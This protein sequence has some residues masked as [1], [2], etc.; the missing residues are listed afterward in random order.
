MFKSKKNLFLIVILGITILTRF[1]NLNWGSPYFFHPDE[2]NMANAVTNMKFLDLNPHFFA[3]GQFPLFLAYFSGVFF[4]LINSNLTIQQVNNS[5][6]FSVSFPQAIFLLRFYSALSQILLLLVIY[7]IAR[8]IFPKNFSHAT[9][10]LLLTTIFLPGLIQSAHFGT[11]ESLL[12]LFLFLTVYFSLKIADNSAKCYDYLFLI[13]TLGFS[14]GTKLTALLF[15]PIPIFSLLLKFLNLN[16]VTIQQFN[17]RFHLFLQRIPAFLKLTTLIIF[18]IFSSLTISFFVSPYN[19]WEYKNTVSTL[20]YE[21]SVANGQSQVFYTRQFINTKPFIFQFQKIFPYT[22][23]PVLTVLGIAGFL[24]MT[25]ELVFR[26]YQRFVQHQSVKS[27]KIN[28]FS[29]LIFSFLIYFIPNSLLFSKWTRF[30]TPI[31]PFFPIFSAYFIVV[32]LNLFTPLWW[33]FQNLFV[34]PASTERRQSAKAGIYFYILHSTFYILLFLLISPGLIFFF[35]VYCHEDIRLS[36]SRFIYQNI[37]SNSH[38][39][40]ETG[41][42]IDIPVSLPNN[43]TIQQFNN[44]ISFDFYHLDENPALLDQLITELA[45]SDYIF[46]PSRRIFANYMRLKEK[47]PL[48]ARYYDLL[49]SGKLGFAKI[50]EFSRLND[51]QAEE[52]WSVFDHPVIRVYKKINFYSKEDYKRLIESK[53]L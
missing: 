38:V 30:M 2:R 1:Y 45:K 33:W 46:V 23:G 20:N 12:T 5:T 3:Y 52:T 13:L 32:I 19:L 26:V 35:Q 34:I 51:E 4:N 40:S 7:K 48:T 29:I 14:L 39:L 25:I 17:N 9:S 28:T 31:F 10:Y 50:I 15:F 49:F 44:P 43:L 37:T 53:F 18:I 8:V 16:N 42:V 22:L 6:I 21:T 11:T 27:F 41:N 47:F 24:L 36:A